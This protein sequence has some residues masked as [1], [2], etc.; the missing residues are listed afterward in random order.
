MKKE[1]PVYRLKL[2]LKPDV[3]VALLGP[4]E[5]AQAVD[6]VVVVSLNVAYKVA[7]VNADPAVG[8]N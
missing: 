5:D 1:L 4:E 2:N 6:P 7:E 8:A 3:A